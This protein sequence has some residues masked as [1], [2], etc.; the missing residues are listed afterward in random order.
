MTDVKVLGIGCANCRTTRAL[1][2]A[3]A[4]DVG[5]AITVEKVEDPQQLRAR[6][7]FDSNYSIRR[8]RCAD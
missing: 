2:E 7:L 8:V 4:R 6:G 5:V 3:V 1:V